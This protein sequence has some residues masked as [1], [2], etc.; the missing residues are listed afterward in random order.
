M[1]LYQLIDRDKLDD[2]ILVTDDL[3]KAVD[4]YLAGKAKILIVWNHEEQMAM[5][6]DGTLIRSDLAIAKN[7]ITELQK[8]NQFPSFIPEPEK[9]E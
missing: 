5:L 9:D 7:I 6:V 1:E 4:S 3:G 2:T 8:S